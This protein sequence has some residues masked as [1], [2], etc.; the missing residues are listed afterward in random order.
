MS[1]N[2]IKLQKNIRRSVSENAK[3]YVSYTRRVLAP[4]VF[5][6]NLDTMDNIEDNIKNDKIKRCRSLIEYNEVRRA[7]KRMFDS[8]EYF[9]DKNT[10]QIYS[11]RQ[12]PHNYSIN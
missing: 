9:M 6:Y 12:H 5:H 11:K 7:K 3:T 1:N 8:G 2:N 10:G 4:Y